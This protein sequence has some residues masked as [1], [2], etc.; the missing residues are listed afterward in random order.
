MSAVAIETQ[1]LSFYDWTDIVNHYA[2]E[3]SE[4]QAVDESC[5]TSGEEQLCQSAKFD[6]EGQI[7]YFHICP[8]D[9]MY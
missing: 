8:H 6:R 5:R 7:D 9:G 2:E 1:A 4:A 3:E